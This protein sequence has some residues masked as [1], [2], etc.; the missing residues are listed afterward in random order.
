MAMHC[1]CN[2]KLAAIVSAAGACFFASSGALAQPAA[3][4]PSAPA[5]QPQP[6]NPKQ[7]QAEPQAQAQTQK[8]LS[9][10]LTGMAKAEYEAGKI[11]Y[12]AKDFGNAIIKFQKA[13][14]LSS[15]PR[16]LWN[17]AICQ[18]E[19]R[20]YTKMLATI[21][22]LLA[23]GGPMLS[24]QDRQDAAA[25]AKT[26]ETFV[27]PLK[28][29]VNEPGAEV[30]ID[31]ERVGTTPLPGP[32][33]VDVGTRSIRIAKKG[34]KE[35][36]ESL[37]VAGGAEIALAVR[38]EKEIHRGR[39][40]VEA[41]PEDMIYL[42]GK[43]VGRG[44]F[45]GSVPSGGHTLRVTSPGMVA[46]QSEVLIE[47]DKTRRI[48][49]YLEKQSDSSKWLWIAGGAALLIGAAVGGAFLFQ[50]SDNVVEGTIEPNIIEITSWR[51]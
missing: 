40:I 17:I 20:R 29:T 43:A 30:T 34:F 36:T 50:P 5:A 6:E 12:Q 15:D 24:E 27:S 7:A 18:K 39:L 23:D 26:V 28:L 38:L 41:R 37:L 10:T 4:K 48:P 45:D 42:D 44:K 3:G 13:Y 32:V 16:L 51:R 35:R 22:K 8:T 21:Q 2:W 31:G 49:V 19:L 9:E 14:E 25:I 47:D 1:A 33:L 46:H 11:L